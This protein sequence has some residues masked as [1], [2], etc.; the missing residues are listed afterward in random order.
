[1]KEWWQKTTNN[2]YLETKHRH[3]MPGLCLEEKMNVQCHWT[4]AAKN[5][6]ISLTP[7][8][9]CTEYC[10]ELSKYRM[11]FKQIAMYNR[12]CFSTSSGTENKQQF[13]NFE[14]HILVWC[15]HQTSDRFTA[16]RKAFSNHQPIIVIRKLIWEEWARGYWFSTI[17]SL[18]YRVRSPAH[19]LSSISATSAE[20]R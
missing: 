1:M 12:K 17:T 5:R 13:H 18:G 15:N 11:N 2:W 14:R 20:S 7:V 4:Y 6:V 19:S 10:K 9:H 3:T 8:G 16:L